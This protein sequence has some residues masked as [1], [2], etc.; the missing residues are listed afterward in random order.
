MRLR[1]SGNAG[2]IATSLASFRRYYAEAAWTWEHLALTRA[3]PV[4]GPPYICACVEGELRAIR[5][6]PRD[7][8]TLLAEVA[9]FRRRLAREHPAAT[10]WS[11][12]TSEGRRVGKGGGSP[13]RSRWSTVN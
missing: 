7:P 10:I 12:E 2:P 5:C 1:P 9:D 13:C 8:E 3:R 6:G 4:A 11:V